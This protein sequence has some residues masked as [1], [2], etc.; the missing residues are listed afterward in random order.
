MCNV[1]TGLVGPPPVDGAGP[2]VDE[3]GWLELLQ[4][5]RKAGDPMNPKP[6]AVKR[7]R[8]KKARRS[9]SCLKSSS[10]PTPPAKPTDMTREGP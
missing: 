4:A 10:V 8:L 3:L 5:A 7:L 2:G 9:K 6:A 1:S